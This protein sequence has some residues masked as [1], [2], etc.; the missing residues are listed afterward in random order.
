M[1]TKMNF[2]SMVFK[3]AHQLCKSSGCSISFALKKAWA[4]YRAFLIKIAHELAAMI[5]AFNPEY[6]TGTHS[7]LQDEIRDKLAAL[8]CNFMGILVPLLT[9]PQVLIH[10][11]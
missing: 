6:F 11:L 8:P 10:F 9:C 1:K 4:K 3:G 2:R 7:D 5:N